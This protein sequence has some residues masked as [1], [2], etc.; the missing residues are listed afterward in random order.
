MGDEYG[1]VC[2]VI[3]LCLVVFVLGCVLG[4][5]FARDTTRWDAYDAGAGQFVQIDGKLGE[6]EW[7][8]N[9]TPRESEGD[10]Q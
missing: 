5:C 1:L 8:W 3:V 9:G 7:R 2:F 10:T 4:G 6:T